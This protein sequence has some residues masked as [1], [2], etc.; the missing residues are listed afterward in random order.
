MLPRIKLFK[1][2]FFY[3]FYK[4]NIFFSTFDKIFSIFPTIPRPVKSY[5]TA[6]L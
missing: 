6:V 3:L 4:F 2:N 5:I 1:V